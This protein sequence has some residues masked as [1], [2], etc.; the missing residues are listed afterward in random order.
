MTAVAQR[1]NAT[2]QVASSSRVP[3]KVSGTEDRPSMQCSALF[4]NN[5]QMPAQDRQLYTSYSH[6]EKN[7]LGALLF[8]G[9][10]VAALVFS[11]RAWKIIW[12]RYKS[13]AASEVE[14]RKSRLQL[15]LT[16]ALLGFSIL[17][18]NML[19]FLILSYMD[20][21]QRHNIRTQWEQLPTLLW[22]WMSHATLFEDFA[23][24]LVSIPAR[25]LWTQLALLQTYRIVTRIYRGRQIARP[26]AM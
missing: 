12:N 1:P 10:I 9:Y 14:K 6:D 21:A 22:Q 11:A 18:Y 8:L 4:T 5:D 26:C 3:I 24:S 20:W 16:L 25:S 13:M 2:C 19:S 17:S 23:R 7:V 15:F